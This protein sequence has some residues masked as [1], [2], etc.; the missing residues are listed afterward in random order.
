[1]YIDLSSQYFKSFEDI[2][3]WIDEWIVSKSKD[4][5]WR[6]IHLLRERW[7]TVVASEGQD[8]KRNITHRKL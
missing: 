3:E 5:Y 7:A 1:M 8:F 6:G 4:F 2:E